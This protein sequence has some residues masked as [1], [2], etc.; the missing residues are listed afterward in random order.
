M[1]LKVF[2]EG[3]HIG[4]LDTT[5]RKGIEFSYTP[6]AVAP[7]SISMPD[8]NRVYSE[9]ECLPFFEGLLPE[10]EIRRQIAEFAHVPATSV[11][12]LLGRY[13][14]DI[15]GALVIT[16]SETDSDDSSGYEPL[17]AGEISR[18]IS[19]KSRIP[20]IVSGER[21]RLSL[22]GAENK[23]PVLYKDGEFLLPFGKAASSHIIKATDEFVENEY[24]CNRLA[25]H[26]GLGVPEMEIVEFEGKQAL[27]IRRFDRTIDSDGTVCRLHQEDFCQALGFMSGNKYEENGGPGLQASM[28]LIRNYSDDPVAD[29]GRF[30]EMAV[31]NYMIGNCDAHAKNFSML[32]DRNLKRKHLAP[33]YD[34]VCS[35]IYGQFDRSLAMKVGRHRNLDRISA[36]DFEG[37]ASKKLAYEAMDHLVSVFPTAI[38][39][40][41][42]ELDDHMHPLLVKIVTDAGARISRLSAL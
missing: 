39:A 33:F 4:N 23:I 2:H 32:Y 36:S 24:I 12:K 13:G 27:L 15:A 28:Q 21:I 31:F 42:N 20:M 8:L 14:A 29:S 35:S 34:V 18:R 22:A 41:G 7:I 30:N 1:R 40:V 9:K 17:S 10:G 19:Q 16:D 25:F 26:S 6:D 5:A 3:N 37:I 11:M 38:E